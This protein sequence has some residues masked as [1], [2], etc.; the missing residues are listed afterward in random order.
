M[1][2]IFDFCCEE[3]DKYFTN[4]SCILEG[5][6]FY[7]FIKYVY[8]CMLDNNNESDALIQF[9][10]YFNMK[11]LS[12]EL[13]RLSKSVSNMPT[14]LYVYTCQPGGGGIT[15]GFFALTFSYRDV[16]QDNFYLLV[17]LMKSIT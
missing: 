11:T 13:E 14:S 2:T 9:Y 16:L 6:L 5:F 7:W 15:L 17:T 4:I 1:K 8:T 3:G 12:F 10:G